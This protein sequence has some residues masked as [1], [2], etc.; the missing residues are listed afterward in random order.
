MAKRSVTHHVSIRA[1]STSLQNPISA[2]TSKLKTQIF[3]LFFSPPFCRLIPKPSLDLDSYIMPSTL[4][5]QQ[6]KEQRRFTMPSFLKAR[7]ISSASASS[8]S[9][10]RERPLSDST[11]NSRL[12]PSLEQ[13]KSRHNSLLTRGKKLVSARRGSGTSGKGDLFGC[14]GEDMAESYNSMMKGHDL[15]QDPVRSVPFALFS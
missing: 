15:G 14:G 12:P 9:H 5:L 4:S 2:P 10:T 6:E 13:H 1:S 3:T 7:P 11:S 8:A